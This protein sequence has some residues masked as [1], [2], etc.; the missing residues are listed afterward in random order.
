[1]LELYTSEGCSSCPPADRWLRQQVRAGIG[2]VLLPLALHVDY[3]DYIGWPDRFADPR[4]AQRQRAR[5]AARGQRIVYTP[6]L[7]LGDQVRLGTR[8]SDGL[9]R[10]ASGLQSAA[11]SVGISLLA[12]PLGEA[13]EVSLDVR[14]AAGTAPLQVWLVHWSDGLSSTVTAGENRSVD[15][16]HD[17]VVRFWQGPW[18]LSHDAPL[19]G[20]TRLPR[21]EERGDGEGISVLLMASADAP[22]WGFDLALH[23][24]VA[25]RSGR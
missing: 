10:L 23:D 20:V 4:H 16:H 11:P 2:E 5:V 1:V 14:A 21:P 19:R 18:P 25:Q 13:I 12:H 9:R 6:Q 15:L 24:C 3:W 8:D 17:R 22:A 7:M